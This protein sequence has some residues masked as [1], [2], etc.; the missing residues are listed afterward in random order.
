MVD[1]DVVTEARPR[2]VN[3]SVAGTTQAIENS[4]VSIMPGLGQTQQIDV[5]ITTE[6][7]D[8]VESA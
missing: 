5:A 7:V 2:S 6:L 3:D 1:R 4:A 8:V